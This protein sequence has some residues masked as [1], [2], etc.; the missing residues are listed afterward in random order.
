MEQIANVLDLD[1][2]P[3][4][5]PDS[6]ACQALV[7]RCQRD[8]DRDGMFNLERLMRSTVAQAAADALLPKVA[9]QAF[10]HK[11]RHNINF[12]P[13]LPDL[14]PDHPARTE[15]ETTNHTLPGD[16][17]AGTAVP[18]VYRW[19]PLINFL[20]RV[21]GRPALYPM[22]DPL[23]CANVMSYGPG[24]AL[25]WHFDR[26]A[27]TTTLL[28]QAPEAGGEFEYR[29]NLRSEADPNYDGVARLLSGDDTGT[30]CMSVTP[31]TLNVFR[32][33]NTAHRTRPVQGS[34]ARLIA[35][36]SYY[37]RPRVR[38]TPDEQIGFYGR[39]A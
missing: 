25:N 28:L 19:Q 24:E 29:R 9:T 12:R 23:A 34:R 8:L 37:D 14:A 27:F 13:D 38:F 17:L 22:D 4:D 30:Q 26:C 39:S 35:V 3:L 10:T 6:A 11:R 1:A 33:I 5:R 20:A 15:F 32:G 18:V 21:M 31:G 36:F 16:Q 7:E 2:F